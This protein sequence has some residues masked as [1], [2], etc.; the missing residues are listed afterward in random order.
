[1]DSGFSWCLDSNLLR[2]HLM[3]IGSGALRNVNENA[4][5]TV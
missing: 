3:I 4:G 2:R 1:M 5:N